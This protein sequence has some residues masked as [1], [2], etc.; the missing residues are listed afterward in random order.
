MTVSE[1]SENSTSPAEHSSMRM[2]DSTHVVLTLTPRGRGS[3]GEQA[4]E[5][6]LAMET[7]LKKQREEMA[8]V[9]QTVFLS[10]PGDWEKCEQIFS[11]R[12]GQRVPVTN[13]VFQP[14]CVDA[15]LTMEVW[16]VGGKSVSVDHFGPHALVVSH[17]GLRWI[18][19]AGITPATP[20]KGVFEQTSNTL[21]QMRAVLD[22]A[23]S[24]FEHVLK[25]WFYL[26]DITQPEAGTHRY[27]ELNRA[28]T[29]FYR[30]I[31]FCSSLLP[32]IVP[33]MA[34]PSSTGIGMAGTGLVA[35]CLALETLRK[36]VFLLP[37][38][39]PLQ[40]PAY[41]YKPLYSNW[42]GSPKFSRAMA[43]V[44]GDYVTTWISGTA[45]I[46]NSES[47]YLRDVEKQTE[48]TIDNIE[49]L[50]SPKNF[51]AHGVPSARAS[52]HDLVTL[53]VYIKRPEY[54]ARV[55]AICERR[56]G[57]VPTVYTLADVCRQELLVEVE[58]VAFS[59]YSSE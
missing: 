18:Y 6:L 32:Q 40:T 22:L 42:I 47:R 21:Q 26:G 44:L 45:S 39:N 35:S 31:P 49:K 54:Y 16:A 55:K 20:S 8:V 11:A 56:F 24:R 2:G 37:L 14:S 30:D 1:A 29:D 38:E 53:R 15:A 13:F 4:K 10:N 48:R 27:E 52:L 28:R 51:A 25:T 7:V 17:D 58:G 59:R 12:Y 9:M 41:A 57:P 46:V 33:K 3:F 23:G 36:D 34:Y 5:I 50:I 43:L 19:C